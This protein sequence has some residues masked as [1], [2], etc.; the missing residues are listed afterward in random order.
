MSSQ[1]D[2]R[3]IAF[4]AAVKR[5]QDEKGSRAS[6]ARAHPWPT[7]ITEDLADFIATVE[8]AFLASASA[9]GQPYVQHRGG[10]PGFIRVL[11]E[12]TLGLAEFAGNRQYITAGNLS[13]NARAHLILMDYRHRRRVKIWGTARHVEDAALTAQLMPQ[14]YRARPE[15]ALLFTVATWDINCPQ[16]IPRL[17]AF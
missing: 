3:D 7:T 13:E 5:I 17:A 4:S 15:G 10:P 11:D 16:H 9:D 8:T 12:T 6:Y 14:G 2:P 1:T